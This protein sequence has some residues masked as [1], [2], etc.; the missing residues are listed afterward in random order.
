MINIKSW[1]TIRAASKISLQTSQSGSA[2][3]DVPA[4]EGVLD[5]S[6]GLP[7]P[8]GVGRESNGRRPLARG[9]RRKLEPEGEGWS[10]SGRC[11]AE[12]EPSVGRGTG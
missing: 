12:G 11:S 2:S 4:A 1:F 3:V 6:L 7:P 8:G 9:Q 5:L 10:E